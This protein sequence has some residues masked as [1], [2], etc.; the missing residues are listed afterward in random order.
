MEN[1]MHKITNNLKQ[2]KL[3]LKMI[4]KIKYKCNQIKIKHKIHKIILINKQIFNK[5][6]MNS[7]KKK[8]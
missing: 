8:Y 3:M 4:N 7:K 5:S 2:N 1:K 6:S